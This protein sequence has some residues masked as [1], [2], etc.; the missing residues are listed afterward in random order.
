MTVFEM[1]ACLI[2]LAAVL[3]YLNYTLLKL[4][5]AIGL[6]ALSLAGSLLLVLIGIAVPAV[7]DK[8]RDIVH[9]IDLNQTFLQGM[10]GFMLFAGAL[11]INLNEL[12]A[13]KWTILV[14]STVGVVISTVVIGLLAWG[15]M[16]AIG[17]PARLIYC[18]LFGALISPT[19]PIAVMAILRQAGVPKAMEIRIAGESLFNDG[20]GV[21]VFMGLLEIATGDIGFDPVRLTGQFLWEAVGGASLGFGLGWIVYRMLRSVDNYQTEVLLSLALVAGGYALVNALHMSGPI[22]MVVAGLLIGN[23]GRA[24]AMSPTTVK[25]LDMFWELIDEILN[26]IL[27]ALIGLEVLALAFTGKLLLLGLVAIP[28][29][30]IARL[31]SV[32]GP[33]TILRRWTRFQKYTIRVLTWGGLRGGI[34][35]ALALS[36]PREVKGE[37][38]VERD[39]ILAMTYVVVVFSIL[40]QGLTVGSLTRYWLARSSNGARPQEE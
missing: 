10:L 20:V 7:E 30:L 32:G 29:V 40:V 28:L 27:F 33:I 3:S 39:A 13:R 34:S 17:V 38:L 26:A 16:N 35:V 37:P 6:T 24:Y 31:V 4:P 25:H 5:P 19:D 21:A 12:A 8:A 14:L 11:H 15:L 2:V 18:L 1:A 22:A 9:R 23:V 36:L